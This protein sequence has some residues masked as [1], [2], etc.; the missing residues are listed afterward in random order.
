MRFRDTPNY[1]FEWLVELFITDKHER[2]KGLIDQ[3]CKLVSNHNGLT[4]RFDIMKFM[5]DLDNVRAKYGLSRP[6]HLQPDP[7]LP[8]GD[9][10]FE[11][12]GSV[13]GYDITYNM[14]YTTGMIK[15]SRG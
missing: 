2:L 3:L 12:N 10:E 6:P 14:I 1:A 8:R 15:D 4:P 11:I 13:S 9:F 7:T 5:E